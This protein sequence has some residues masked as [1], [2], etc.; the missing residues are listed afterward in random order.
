[1]IPQPQ[2]QLYL[3]AIRTGLILGDPLL[4][5]TFEEWKTSA[6]EER[7]AD[8]LRLAPPTYMKSIQQ[9]F[10]G[11]SSNRSFVIAFGLAV[12]V[13]YT[14]PTCF[15]QLSPTMAASQMERLARFLLSVHGS[16]WLFWIG[17]YSGCDAAASNGWLDFA[18]R[19]SL[20]IG[21]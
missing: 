3:T 20:V 2:L 8:F 15:S 7:R 12:G 14:I 10:G 21:N 6:R 4:L 5:P 13:F 11:S 9:V 18:F 17:P 19:E 16:P 1:M